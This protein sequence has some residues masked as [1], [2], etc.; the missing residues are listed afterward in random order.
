MLN[1]QGTPRLSDDG[2]WYWEGTKWV[3]TLSPDG[4]YRWTGTAWAPVRKM[5]LGDYANQSI[6]SA[7]IGIFCALFFPFGL[8]AGYKAYQELPHKRTQ[9]IV[10]LVLNT[11]GVG[12]W[13]FGLMSR[14]LA[15]S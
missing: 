9:A 12:L 4:K 1:P 14:F 10:G 6:A 13:I 8:Y 15:Q 7:I 11:A 2:N 3:S 5:F